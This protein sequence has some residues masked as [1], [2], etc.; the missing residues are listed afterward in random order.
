M[1][2]TI[3][4]GLVSPVMYDYGQK[5]FYLQDDDYLVNPIVTSEDDGIT[6]IVRLTQAEYDALATKVATTLYVIVEA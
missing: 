1:A 6:K 3:G 2:E 5:K 4:A